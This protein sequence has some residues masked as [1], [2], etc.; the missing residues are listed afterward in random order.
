MPTTKE[1]QQ[2]KA[3][4]IQ[5]NQEVLHDNLSGYVRKNL[6]DILNELPESEADRLCHAKRYERNAGRASTRSGYYKRKLTTTSGKVT[7]N[8]PKLRNLPFETAIIER[9]R[10][11]ES[12]IEEAMIEMYL[13][14]VSVRRTEDTTEALWGARVSAGT[15]SNLNKKIY[16]SIDGWR[17]RPLEAEYPYIYMDGIWLKRSW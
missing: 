5:I 14:G 17:N 9:Y 16:G 6:E 7:L 2:K 1:S 13:A 10:R 15:I 8:I 11:R 12:S 4:V 3:P